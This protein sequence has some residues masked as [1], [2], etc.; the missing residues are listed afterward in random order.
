MT[1]SRSRKRAFLHMM[2]VFEMMTQAKQVRNSVKLA[3]GSCATQN[4]SIAIRILSPVPS[5][6]PSSPSTDSRRAIVRSDT[7]DS[8]ANAEN[9]DLDPAGATQILDDFVTRGKTVV[10][11]AL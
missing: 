2:T 6:P 5:R 11:H 10:G 4:H 7:P 9:P 8:R 3:D 1:P